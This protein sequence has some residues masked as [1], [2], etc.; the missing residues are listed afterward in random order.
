MQTDRIKTF[1]LSSSGISRAVVVP[2]NAH[3]LNPIYMHAINRGRALIKAGSTKL[4]EFPVCG[5]AEMDGVNNQHQ[6]Y[7]VKYVLFSLSLVMIQGMCT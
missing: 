6:L 3:D 7:L 1:F 5:L 2:I 4:R